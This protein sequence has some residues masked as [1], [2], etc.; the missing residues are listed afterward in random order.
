MCV[1]VTDDLCSK[2]GA[3]TTY[4]LWSFELKLSLSLPLA[5]T[6]HFT[7]Q[8][9]LAGRPHMPTLTHTT[10]RR[11][12]VSVSLGNMA[13]LMDDAIRS[14]LAGDCFHMWSVFCLPAATKTTSKLSS[15]EWFVPTYDVCLSLYLSPCLLRNLL[16]SPSASFPSFTACLRSNMT[17]SPFF[18]IVS[19]PSLP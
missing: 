15:F 16:C 14:R 17:P 13:Q 2:G 1:L 5:E 8:H 9:T 4:F 19:T 10:S 12:L 11:E 6:A 3:N 7:K 18:L